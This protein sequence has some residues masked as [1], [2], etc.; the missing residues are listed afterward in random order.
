MKKTNNPKNTSTRLQKIY[1][2]L[3]IISAIA[4]LLSKVV[5][6]ISIGIINDRTCPFDGY[7]QVCG[8]TPGIQNYYNALFIS[9]GWGIVWAIILL[10][11]SIRYAILKKSVS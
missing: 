7:Q 6:S 10:I 2:A 8:L 1:L 9:I 4:L 11:V 3:I 5:Y